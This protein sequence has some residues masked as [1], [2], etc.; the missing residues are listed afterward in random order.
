M[1]WYEGKVWATNDEGLWVISDSRI[2]PAAVP[3][4]VSESAGNLSVGDGVMLLAG[5]GGSS[6]MADGKWY[7]IFIFDKM[8]KLLI[9]QQGSV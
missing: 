7:E 8:D 2:E 4:F 3:D 6:Y 1:V 9:D 5:T